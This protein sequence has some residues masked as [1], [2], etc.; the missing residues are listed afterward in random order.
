[1]GLEVGFVDHQC[2]DFTASIGQFQLHPGK[3]SFLA[4]MYSA[5]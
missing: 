3:L 2:P 4:P 5:V 1:M